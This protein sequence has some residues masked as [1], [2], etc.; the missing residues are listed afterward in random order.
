MKTY[1]G[2]ITKLE[3]NQVFVFGSNRDGFHGAGA[4]GFASFGEKG[5]VWRKYNYASKPYGWKGKWNIKGAGKG[6]QEGTEG[7]SYAIPT[8]IKAGQKCSIP[9]AEIKLS[10]NCFYEFA[11]K[12]PELEF[13]VAY[14]KNNNLNGYSAYDM[15]LAF[16]GDIPKNV[17]FERN[18]AD[19]ISVL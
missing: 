4:A 2:E 13:L 15:A 1:S 7:K 11:V 16:K 12:H 10:V 9:L 18:F 19:M 3:A 14:S 5:N 6:F 17:V 8:V